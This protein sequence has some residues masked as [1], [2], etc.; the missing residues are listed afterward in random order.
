[1]NTNLEINSFSN[2]DALAAAVAGRW[3]DEVAFAGDHGLPH[4]VALSGG[5]IAARLFAAVT[6]QNRARG[7]SFAPAQFFWADERCVPPADSESNYRMA[8][9]GLF[10]PLNVPAGRIHRLKGEEEP[11]QAV[12]EASAEILALA[13][14]SATGQPVLDLVLLGMGEDGHVA[15]LFPGA[16]AELR[17]LPG[18][19]LVIRNSPKPPPNRLS[20]SYAALGA[21]RQ[22]WVL[23]SG[24]GKETALRQSLA[25]PEL[26]PLGR[27]IA[28]RGKTVLFTDLP[29]DP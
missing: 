24:A 16:A 28:S 10:A 1:M 23:A 20:L 5:R 12:R 14:A 8:A 9:E 15:S 11:E 7:V 18:P 3:L 22:V 26:T 21:V 17:A 25:S 27:V 13:P 29:L 2:A 6:A 19:F 4:R